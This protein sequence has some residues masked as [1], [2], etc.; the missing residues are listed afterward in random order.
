MP[1]YLVETPTKK[2]LVDASTAA[3][4]KNHIIKNTVT[5]KALTATELVTLIGEG[6][7]VEKAA[8]D[9]SQ[10]TDAPVTRSEDVKAMDKA[11]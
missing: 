1:I 5:A 6:L 7:Q 4:A 8:V 9:L 11:E 10:Q 2:H 3:S